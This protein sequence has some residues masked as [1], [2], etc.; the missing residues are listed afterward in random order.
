MVC[1]VKNLPANAGDSRNMGSIPGLGRSPGKGNSN[2]LH[3][4]AWKIPWLEELG[5]LQ[6]ME[7]QTVRDNR[8]S[9]LLTYGKE[10]IMELE[11]MYG[12]QPS[13]EK[14]MEEG[15]VVV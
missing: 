5:G 8:A 15:K 11:I 12:L 2:S 6:S 14:E 4:L 3:I 9:N 7:S 1:T 13:Q 10:S